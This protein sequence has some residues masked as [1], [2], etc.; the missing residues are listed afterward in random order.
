VTPERGG[1]FM[2]EFYS[3]T[4]DAVRAASSLAGL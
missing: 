4:P 1:A 2:Y 3:V